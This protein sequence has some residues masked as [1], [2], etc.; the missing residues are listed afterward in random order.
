MDGF[1]RASL[2]ASMNRDVAPFLS[3]FQRDRLA[4]T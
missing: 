3:K 2:V 1:L 4:D